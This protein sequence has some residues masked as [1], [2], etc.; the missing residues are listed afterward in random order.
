MELHEVRAGA[1][2][3]PVVVDEAQVGA[4]APAPI[5][6]TGVGSWEGRESKSIQ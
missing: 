3:R 5:G 1:G 6:L 4:G 2:N